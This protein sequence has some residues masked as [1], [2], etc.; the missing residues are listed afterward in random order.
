MNLSLFHRH[1]LTEG[2]KRQ[3][4]NSNIFKSPLKAGSFRSLMVGLCVCVWCVCVFSK[5]QGAYALLAP[6]MESLCWMEL[7]LLGP[8][9]PALS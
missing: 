6:G 8:W 3:H 9:A 4:L 7:I 2:E 5:C 1:R